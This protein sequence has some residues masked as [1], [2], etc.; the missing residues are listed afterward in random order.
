MIFRSLG[1]ISGAAVSSKFMH[2]EP[3]VQKYLGITLLPQAGVSLG[4]S[5]TAMSLGAPGLIIRNVAL[6]AVLIYELVGPLL[7]RIALDKAGEI[8]EKP[9][10]E[11]EK[12]K[13]QK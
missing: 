6:F 4:M 3:A 9:V 5:L 11:R 2:C 1:K 8:H 13:A 10:T 7:T 12:A